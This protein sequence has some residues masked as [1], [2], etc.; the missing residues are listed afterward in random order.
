MVVR[1]CIRCSLRG[2]QAPVLVS[3]GPVPSKTCV[4]ATVC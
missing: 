4:M 3:L 2:Q 1:G